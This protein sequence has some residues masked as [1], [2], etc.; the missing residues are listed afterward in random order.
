MRDPFRLLL[1][2]PVLW[3]TLA[4]AQTSPP[5]PPTAQQAIE[6]HQP[7]VRDTINGPACR[8]ATIEEADTIYVCGEG[9]DQSTGV[10]SA[11]RPE[12]NQFEA[13]DDGGAWFRTT[14]GPVALSCCSVDGQR[15][16]AA[17]I[18]LRIAF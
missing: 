15:G 18:G 5:P 12:R 11:Y 16:S 10:R 4:H 8:P 13:P 3:P 2:L 17:G 7:Q 1:A 9:I 14:I 6:R